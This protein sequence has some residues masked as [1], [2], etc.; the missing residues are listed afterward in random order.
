M[1]SGPP[2]SP[3]GLARAIHQADASP[4]LQKRWV[5]N[6]ENSKN[7][8]MNYESR[9]SSQEHRLLWNRLSLAV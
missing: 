3:G 2:F 8:G 7:A 5:S 4:A 1:L 9:E 6:R